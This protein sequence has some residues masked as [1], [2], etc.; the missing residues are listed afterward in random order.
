MNLKNFF[1]RWKQGIL[2]MTVEQQLKN[3]MILF[4]G[5][6]IGMLL[7]TITFI[8]RRSWGFS[9]FLFCMVGFQL[10]SFIGVRQQLIQYKKNMEEVK[11]QQEDIQSPKLDKELGNSK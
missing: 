10:I 6:A 9:I 11:T 5:G 1:K 3:K 7:A 2:D 4:I 8:I